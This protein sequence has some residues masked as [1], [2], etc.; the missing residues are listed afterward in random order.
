[1]SKE[2][3]KNSQSKSTFPTNTNTSNNQNDQEP[4][5]DEE[6]LQAPSGNPTQTEDS[7][8][9]TSNS[10]IVQN[11]GKINSNPYMNEIADM[12][13]AIIK[14][15]LE[16]GENSKKINDLLNLIDLDEHYQNMILD[17]VGFFQRIKPNY[18][19]FQRDINEIMRAILV[20]WLIDVHHRCNMK[21]K[22]LYQCVFIIDAYLS[23]N[24]IERINL[25]LLGVSAF[26]I[27]CKQNEAIYPTLQ[28]CVDFTANA[29][30]VQELVDMEQLVLQKLDYDVL[31]PTASEFFEIIADYFEFTEKQRFFGEYFL[32]ASLMDYY[33]LKY[34][35]S[36][37]AVA[38][39]YLVTK[40]F[41]LNGNNLILENTSPEVKSIEVKE[42]AKYLCYFMENL[43]N[44]SLV[45]AKDKYMSDKYLKVA[46]LIKEN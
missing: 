24:I 37:I 46:E 18:M 34:K 5:K 6:Q 20:D 15:N 28:N 16:Q 38:C 9:Q 26:L 23:K 3:P 31:T 22:T 39:G 40:F 17:E 44:S 30:T 2:N 10:S 7:S 21:K 27:A 42:C 14:N 33:L 36:T 1:M 25:Q 4:P 12:I 41:G 19:S 32:D 8:N 45:A 29:Y 11:N 43:V 35:Q 13:S